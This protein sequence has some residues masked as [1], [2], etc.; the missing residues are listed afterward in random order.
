M[1]KRDGVLTT[2]LCRLSQFWPVRLAVSMFDMLGMGW[3]RFNSFSAHNWP[4]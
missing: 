1:V 2:V 4:L 3:L